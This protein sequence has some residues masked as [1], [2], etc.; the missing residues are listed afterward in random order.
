MGAVRCRPRLNELRPRYKKDNG[1]RLNLENVDTRQMVTYR[2]KLD[3]ERE[4]RLAAKRGDSDEDRKKKKKKKK[5]H[6]R[7]H[8]HKDDDDLSVVGC[9]HSPL[10][11]L[12]V[13]AQDGSTRKRRRKRDDEDAPVR[14]SDYLQNDDDD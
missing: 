12:Q 1:D 13:A 3:A 11:S 4:A 14:L 2:R 7:K 10:R 9:S 5:K 6:K 8:H